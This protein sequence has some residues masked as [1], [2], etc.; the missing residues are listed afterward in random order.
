MPIPYFSGLSWNDIT[1]EERFYC[2]AL[3]LHAQNDPQAFAAWVKETAR[4]DIDPATDW[5]IGLE[6]CFYRDYLWHKGKP[7][8]GSGFSPK[9][10]F[11]L[12][13]FSTKAIVIIEAKVDQP[14]DV[15]QNETFAQDSQR[16]PE[17]L[18]TKDIKVFLVALASSKYFQSDAKYGNGESLRAFQGQISWANAYRKYGDSLLRQAD[19]LYGSKVRK[20]K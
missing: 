7:V 10:T 5:D 17:L 11:D 9:R 12:C 14:F 20:L 13:L 15:E 19:E 1:R 4:L 3:Y 6:V 8:H 18:D 16:I 2:F